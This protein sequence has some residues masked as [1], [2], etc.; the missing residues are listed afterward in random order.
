MFYL[1]IAAALLFFIAH[2]TLLF[3][4]FPK[5][6]LNST[7]YLYSHVTLWLTGLVV[8]CLALLYSGNGQSGFLDYFDTQ[9]KKGL[10]LAFTV[11]LSLTAHTIVRTL[12]L[13][14]MRK[15]QK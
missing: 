5:S 12:I 11:A 9:A 2:V 8:F 4:A 3:M 1:L 7:R 10:I 13:P 14:M 6:Q 15:N